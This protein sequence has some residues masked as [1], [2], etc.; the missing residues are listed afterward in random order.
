MDWYKHI[1]SKQL[2]NIQPVFFS[3][4]SPLWS[5]TAVTWINMFNDCTTG[6][7]MCLVLGKCSLWLFWRCDVIIFPPTPCQLESQWHS[8][9][10]V[11]YEECET[12]FI[13]LLVTNP[14]TGKAREQQHCCTGETNHQ[15]TTS[16]DFPAT[17]L[18]VHNT[19]YLSWNARSQFVPEGQIYTHDSI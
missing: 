19:E 9:T 4:H 5:S 13:I 1:S 17:H 7:S 18:P 15:H 14:H 16:H 12:K 10:T 6:R 2:I 3:L 11:A 8:T